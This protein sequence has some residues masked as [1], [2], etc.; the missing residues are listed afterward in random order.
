VRELVE[1]ALRYW[2][3]SWEDQSDSQAPHEASMLNLVIDKAH[4]QLGWTSRWDF[5]TT[6]ER[7]VGWY[8]QVEDGHAS[9][10]ACCLEDIKVFK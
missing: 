3:G 2:P 5:T 7:T 9:A 8:R 1:E 6:V 10:L 4:H